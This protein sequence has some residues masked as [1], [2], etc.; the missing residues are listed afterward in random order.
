MPCLQEV[1]EVTIVPEKMLEMLLASETRGEL[2]ILFHKNPGLID[3]M[4]GIARRIGKTARAIEQEVNDFIRLG[5]LRTKPVGNG[6][7]IYLNLEK[8]R[9]IQ[10]SIL[11]YI[12]E[13]RVR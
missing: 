9:E 11:G 2:L 3:T 10:N 7:A 8:D 6:Q 4:E 13:R 12:K 5:I 1:F